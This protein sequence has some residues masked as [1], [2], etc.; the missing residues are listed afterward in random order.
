MT[1]TGHQ[2]EATRVIGGSAVL[3]I[4]LN[5]CLIPIWDI[6][7]AAIATA[8]TTATW[9]VVLTFFVWQRLGLRATAI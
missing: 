9:N 7:G 4:L 8:V 5:A 2:K 6:Q 3:N 1:M